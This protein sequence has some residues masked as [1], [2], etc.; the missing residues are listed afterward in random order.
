MDLPE[1]ILQQIS[2]G[3]TD[4]LEI[5]NHLNVDHQ[6]VIGAI[7]SLESLGNVISSESYVIKRWQLTEEGQQVSQNGSHEAIVYQNVPKDGIAQ[8]ALMKLVGAV[9]KVGFSKAMS[10]GW[11]CID[12]GGDKLVKPKVETIVDQVKENLILISSGK[13]DSIDN[14]SRD[15]YKKRKLLH[16]VNFT[17]YKVSKGS[18]FK[19]TIEKAVTDLTPEMIASGSW[20]NANFKPYNFAALGISPQ[21]GHL[22][23][24]LKVRAEYRQIFLEM[25]FSEMP[26]NNYVE[27]SFWNFDALFQPQQHPA[28]DAQDTFFISDPAISTEFPPEYLEKVRKVH[29][30]GGFGSQGYGTDWKIEET[31]KNI[32]RT[33]T[34]AVSARMLYKLGQNQEFVP[35]KYFSI[36]RVFRNETLDATHLAE[37]HQI[38]GVV[39]DYNLTLGDLIGIINEFFKKL[40]IEKL[41][42]KPAYNPYTEPSMEIFSYHEGLKKWVEIGNSGIFR[43]EMLLPMGLPENVNVIAWGL[44]LERP[45]M[46][47]YGI[48]NIRDLVGHKVNLK[49]VQENPICRLQ[50]DNRDPLV[51]LALVTEKRWLDIEE[52]LKF[53]QKQVQNICDQKGLNIQDISKGL[54]I[55]QTTSGLNNTFKDVVIEMD[56]KFPSQSIVYLAKKLSQV[57]EVIFASHVHS[58]VVAGSRV[59]F[60]DFWPKC[61][62]GLKSRLEYDLALTLIWKSVGPEPIM[63]FSGSPTCSKVVG[64]PNILRYLARL[65][66][67]GNNDPLYPETSFS[68]N[69]IDSQLDD[70]YGLKSGSS[71]LAKSI[72][73]NKR[74]QSLNSTITIADIYYHFN[75]KNLPELKN[76]KLDHNFVFIS[77]L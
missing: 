24:L 42:F 2:Q 76:I 54:P 62:N 77:A 9:G 20:K 10:A 55:K 52:Q 53:L 56:P 15:E 47:K 37:F 21:A 12:K 28:R 60:K 14:K 73:S 51:N 35:Q 6:K 69:W 32:L 22:H 70:L 7:K 5:A 75:H 63:K 57:K 46:I 48:D 18:E 44:S 40:G 11:I 19:L 64:E 13:I 59:Q 67:T 16:E 38:E 39:A 65:Q 25:G 61:Q 68:V 50:K 71:N 27:S 49:M 4:S 58:S 34:T 29:S 33:H 8:P 31:Q 23:P 26:T 36:D 45:T 74:P 66:G 30:Q 1:T 43:P 72:A 17:A 3:Q 41:R